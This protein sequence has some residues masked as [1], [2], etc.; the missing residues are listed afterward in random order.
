MTPTTKRATVYLEQDLHRALKLKAAQTDRSIS[1]LINEAVR[2]SM[3]EDIEDLQSLRERVSEPDVP[4]ETVLKDL[5][6][7]GKL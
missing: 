6:A 7:R 5:R 4:Y 1:D 3:I 2:M